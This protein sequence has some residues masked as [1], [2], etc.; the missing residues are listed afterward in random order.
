VVGRVVNGSGRDEKRASRAKRYR[1]L[2]VLL[3]NN[4]AFENVSD[5][6]ARVGM[7]PNGRAGLKLGNSGHGLM[8]GHR[9]IA[10]LEHRTFEA[11][12]LSTS[13]PGTDDAGEGIPAAAMIAAFTTVSFVIASK[14]D[15]SVEPDHT[16]VA[17][18]CSRPFWAFAG[19]Y[20]TLL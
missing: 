16:R 11:A 20:R 10:L 9:E 4:R 19:T 3:E 14:C 15:G 18:G 5:L 1:R 6:F 7:A 2:A 17:S 8:A 13:V 12:L